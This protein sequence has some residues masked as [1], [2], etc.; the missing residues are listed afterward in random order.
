MGE[1]IAV[2]LCVV[3]CGPGFRDWPEPNGGD[4]DRWAPLKWSGG[5]NSPS[6]VRAREAG[7]GGGE[8]SLSALRGRKLRAV[9]GGYGNAGPK[10]Q[11]VLRMMTR[12]VSPR[13]RLPR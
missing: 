3:V 10:R 11:A 6:L 8:R 2:C 5:P 12:P 4:T 9:E 1:I 7:S 13:L